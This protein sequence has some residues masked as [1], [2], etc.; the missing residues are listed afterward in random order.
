MNTHLEVPL[1]A[2][3]TQNTRLLVLE[4]LVDVICVIAVHVTLLHELL[5]RHGCV[6]RHRS[7]MN[8]QPTS[9]VKELGLNVPGR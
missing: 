1:D 6:M 2:S 3:E 9:L 4:V 7:D 8:G 5:L